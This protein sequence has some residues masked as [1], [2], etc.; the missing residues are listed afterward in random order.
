MKLTK[1]EIFNYFESNTRV[2]FKKYGKFIYRSADLGETILTIVSGKLETIK[3]AGINEIVIRNIE[4]GS[5]AE[6]YII[7]WKKF[8]E[9]Y[10]P[11]L[12]QNYIIE[13]LTWHVA[14]AKGI[15]EAFEYNN[16]N[17]FS[18]PITFMAPWNEEMILTLGDWLAR[19]KDGDKNDIYR[20]E[21]ETFHKTY[22]KLDD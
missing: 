3:T 22:K 14:N 15:I 20:I 2:W 5:S 13:G 6:T 8:C 12:Q 4:I 21:K 16:E 9:R 17:W 10:N 11:E 18:E 1:D 19:T 7:S